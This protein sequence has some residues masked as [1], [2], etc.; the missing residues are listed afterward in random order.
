MKKLAV[1]MLL[2]L[3]AGVGFAQ[4]QDYWDISLV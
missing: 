2:V 3:A 4:D 1:V